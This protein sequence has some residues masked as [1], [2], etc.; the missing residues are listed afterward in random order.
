MSR[1][2]AAA[3][4]ILTP[5]FGR[6]DPPTDLGAA[7]AD[8]WRSVVATKPAD[9]F[10]RD[11]QP[12]LAAY[13]QA[14]VSWRNISTQV[15]AFDVAWLATDDGLKRYDRLMKMQ[16]RQARVMASMATK[17]RL[18]QQSKYGPRAADTASKAGAAA[19]PWEQRS[20][21]TAR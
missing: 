1:K 21:S 20:A 16:D 19:K 17:M 2:S 14:I 6:P 12:L 9:W 15:A 7:E 11:T 13:C 10:T 4:S 3:L 8:L 5:A 18:T